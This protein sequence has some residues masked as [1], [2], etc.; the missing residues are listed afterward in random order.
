MVTAKDVANWMFDEFK[1]LGELRQA[2]AA[3]GIK[4]NFGEQFVY[5]NQNGNYGISKEVLTEFN[6]MTAAI[7]VWERGGKYWRTRQKNDAPG[8]SSRW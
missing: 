3:W 8:R 1:R 7:A 5:L 2:D 4:E 6:K